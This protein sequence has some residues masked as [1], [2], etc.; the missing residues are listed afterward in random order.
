[1]L[2]VRRR[3]EAVGLPGSGQELRELLL[4]LHELLLTGEGGASNRSS[5]YLPAS[6][7]GRKRPTPGALLTTAARVSV[8]LLGGA[9]YWQLLAE[10]VSDEQ[11][12][13][14]ERKLSQG[15]VELGEVVLAREDGETET[16]PWFLPPRPLE[17]AHF[18]ALAR[19]LERVGVA[20]KGG[21]AAAVVSALADFHYRF[22]RIHPLPSANQSLSMSFVN[23]VLHHLLGV[24]IPHLLLDQLALRFELGAYRQLF[25]RAVD[26]WSLP[27][28]SASERGRALL[29]FRGELN[30]F[31][32]ELGRAATLVEARGLLPEGGHGARLA[33]LEA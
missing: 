11:A 26:A 14:P 2:A 19:D 8:P 3:L 32:A 17:E 6:R 33:L 5:F 31:V 23:A 13:A 10:S 24:G 27:G 28:V 22:V 21:D 12:L 7:L 4:E 20:R 9:H 16:R 18:E 15:G 25:G 29:R 30:D 1:M